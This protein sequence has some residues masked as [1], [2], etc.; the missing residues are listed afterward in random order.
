MRQAKEA[1]KVT[2]NFV[3]KVADGSVI[4]TTHT[5]P[6]EDT[7]NDDDCCHVYGPM[8]LTI[9]EGEFYLPI[10]AALI[11]MHIGDKKSVVISPDDAFGDYDPENIFSTKRSDFADDITPEIG[12]ELEVTGEDDEIYMVAIVEINDEEITFDA[13]HP[14]AGEELTYEIELV[15]IL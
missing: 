5:D 11:G 10:E 6:A 8:E 12:L 9:G 3:G 4:D 14:L 2:I 13:N 7:C 15:E 1:D